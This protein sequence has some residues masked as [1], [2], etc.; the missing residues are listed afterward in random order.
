MSL[1]VIPGVLAVSGAL[2][3]ARFYRVLS[4]LGALMAAGGIVMTGSRGGLLALVIG[5][6]SVLFGMRNWNGRLKVICVSFGTL[7]ILGGAVLNDP[8]FRARLESSFETRDTAGREDIWQDSLA[9][10][11]HHPLFGFGNRSSTSELGELRGEGTRAT[12]NLPLSVLLATGVVGSLA[13]LC[14]YLNAARAAW[15]HRQSAM[16][17]LVFPWFVIALVGSLSLN[18]EIA[19]WYWLITALA[20]AVPKAQA[21]ET[22]KVTGF[23]SALNDSIETACRPPIDVE[24]RGGDARCQTRQASVTDRRNTRITSP[25]LTHGIP[26]LGGTQ[27]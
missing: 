2:P 26:R 3:V 5:I 9:L 7:G 25:W 27:Q 17:V 16:G 18:L 4:V 13:F 15:R 19:K 14:F 10:S 20:L 24:Q 1:A 22:R 8:L 21:L 23:V 11:L 6:A 12:H